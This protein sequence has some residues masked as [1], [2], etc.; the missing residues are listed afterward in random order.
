[1][2]VSQCDSQTDVPMGGRRLM[3]RSVVKRGLVREMVKLM[4]LRRPKKDSSRID[5][6]PLRVNPNQSAEGRNIELELQYMALELSPYVSIDKTSDIIGHLKHHPSI[7][8]HTSVSQPIQASSPKDQAKPIS[9]VTKFIKSSSLTV[10][11]CLTLTI[12]LSWILPD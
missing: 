10:L 4:E 2:T 9:F 12:I 1:M 5:L 8:A 11:T 7:P 6:S 3:N